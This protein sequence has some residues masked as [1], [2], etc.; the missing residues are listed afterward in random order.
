MNISYLRLFLPYGILIALVVFFYGVIHAQTIVVD[1]D[2]DLDLN[3]S[4][5]EYELSRLDDLDL[6]HLEDLDLHLEG[7]SALERLHEMDFSEM[8]EHL[9]DLNLSGMEEGLRD[10]E[11]DLHEMARDLERDYRSGDARYFR[12]LG[13]L[14]IH[15]DGLDMIA[16]RDH[17]T[18][19]DGDRLQI[20]ALRRLNP[21]DPETAFSVL[22]PVLRDA[23]HPA[24]RRQAV[25]TLARGDDPERVV[26]LLRRVVEDDSD[27]RVRREAIRQLGRIDHPRA[28]EALD[29]ILDQ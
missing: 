6:S 5:L 4:E 20:E 3:L 24:V 16:D 17:A 21:R 27:I 9:R 2:V 7:L 22:E 1:P 10:M 25:R 11:A 28:V 13:D 19:S 29:A 18:L 14:R 12:H 15:L 26:D 8:E 23:P